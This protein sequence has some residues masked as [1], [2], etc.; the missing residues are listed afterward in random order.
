[1]T[2]EDWIQ[3]SNNVLKFDINN[4]NSDTFT[5]IFD[6]FQRS[7]KRWRIRFNVCCE[8]SL[9]DK[10]DNNFNN[11]FDNDMRSHIKSIKT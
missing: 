5:D 6:L 7:D 4:Y 8:L 2:S 1:M 3:R 9:S 10:F 11:D